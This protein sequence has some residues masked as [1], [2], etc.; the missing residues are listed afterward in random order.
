[1]LTWQVYEAEV[2]VVLLN[3]GE[4]AFKHFLKC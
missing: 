3:P 1:M 2:N 4:K